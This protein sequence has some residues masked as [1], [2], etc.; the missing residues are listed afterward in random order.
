MRT[1]RIVFPCL[2]DTRWSISCSFMLFQGWTWRTTGPTLKVNFELLNC[3][4]VI[5]VQFSKKYLEKIKKTN[6]ANFEIEK[7]SS[8]NTYFFGFKLEEKVGS[9]IRNWRVQKASERGI[10]VKATIN[11]SQSNIYCFFLYTTTSTM[12]KTIPFFAILEHKIK[13]PI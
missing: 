13:I 1:I 7:K 6:L 5:Y 9:R 2:S 8:S 4:N 10:E 11:H 3:T 12:W